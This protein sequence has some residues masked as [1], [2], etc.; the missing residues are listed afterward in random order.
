MEG[1]IQLS[2]IGSGGESDQSAFV[3]R[4]HHFWNVALIAAAS[5]LLTWAWLTWLQ[6][7]FM[8]SDVYVYWLDSLRW[9]TPYNPDH[10]AGYPL[11]IAFLRFLTSGLVAPLTL[12]LVVA[13]CAHLAGALAVFRAVASQTTDRIGY[14]SVLLFVLWP[15]TG[16]TYAAYPMSDGLALALLAWGI[17]LLLM[18]RTR[19]AAIPLGVAAVIHKGT[20]IFIIFLMLAAAIRQ[21]RRFSWPAPLIAGLPLGLLWLAGMVFNHY[22]PFWLLS[23][24]LPIQFATKS[25]LPL[26]D[27]ILGAALAGG[28]R[29]LLKSVVLWAHVGML[30]TLLVSFIRERNAAAKWYGLAVVCGLLFLY[31]G[32]NQNII[33]AAVRYSKIAAL[34]LGF[35]FGSHPRFAD[36][37]LRRPWRVVALTGL[38]F[39]SQLIYS[40]YM[41][42]FYFAGR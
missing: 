9:R 25:N 27:G 3:W 33:W 38:L 37:F 6:F 39:A 29:Y 32:L 7:Q 31:C 2:G 13:F 16:S 40:L 28:M 14:L 42:R 15:F 35:Y 1:E 30:V 34:P 36:F 12:F 22:G 24:S 41:A 19:T 10:V 4:R 20:W 11:L 5:F 26:L 8:Q 17:A 21:R 18:E 23:V